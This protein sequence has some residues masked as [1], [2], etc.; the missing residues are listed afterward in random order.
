MD[1][2]DDTNG[3]V[4]NIQFD[5]SVDIIDCVLAEVSGSGRHW[6][7]SSKDWDEDL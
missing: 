5:S 4:V 1:V 3:W 2:P 7:L 6:S